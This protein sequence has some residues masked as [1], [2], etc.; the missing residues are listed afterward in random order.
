MT[1]NLR[2]VVKFGG[3]SIS[4]AKNIKSVAKFIHSL[5]KKNQVVMVCSAVND[6]TDQLLDIS[7]FIQ[8]G[9]KDSANS[10]MLKIIKEHKQLAKESITNQNIRKKLFEKLDSDLSELQGLL[11]GMIL[12]G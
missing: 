12:L 11:H 5:S 10:L 3:T 4:T 8:K 7:E 2:L 6:V 1:S 9:N